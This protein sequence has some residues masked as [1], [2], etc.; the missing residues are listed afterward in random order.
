MTD[1]I[2]SISQIIAPLFVFLLANTLQAQQVN[3]DLLF[4]GKPLEAIAIGKIA[5]GDSSRKDPIDLEQYTPKNQKIVIQ[6]NLDDLKENKIGYS[7]QYQDPDLAS[8]GQSYDVYKVIAD[9][10]EHQYLVLVESS[11]GGSGQFTN[12][13]VMK[14]SGDF[15][16][17]MKEIAGGDRA[18]GGIVSADYKDGLVTVVEQATPFLV[19]S[20]VL[21]LTDVNNPLVQLDNPGNLMDCAACDAGEITLTGKIDEKLTP[22]S[23]TLLVD[24]DNNDNNSK[25]DTLQGAFDKTVND[26][27][28]KGKTTLNSEEMGTFVKQ[29]LDT[30]N[31]SKN[32]SAKPST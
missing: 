16:Q 17:N 23:L 30:F 20:T 25:P 1:F 24:N 9:L 27:R 22:V 10:G 21:S 11:G 32:S 31:M 26:Y 4:N 2:K 8:Q 19:F 6:E 5:N 12:L 13:F 7:Y 14:R 15:I 18:N 3:S 28:Q 29:V